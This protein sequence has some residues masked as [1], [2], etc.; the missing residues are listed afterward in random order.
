MSTTRWRDT[1]ARFYTEVVDYGSDA[2]EIIR[3]FHRPVLLS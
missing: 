1:R 3:P 2:Y